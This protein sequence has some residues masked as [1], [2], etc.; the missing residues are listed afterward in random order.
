MVDWTYYGLAITVIIAYLWVLLEKIFK[1]KPMTIK[2]ENK[3]G[4]WFCNGRLYKD[5]TFE[6]KQFF[7][8]F[9]RETRLDNLVKNQLDKPLYNV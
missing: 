4:K 3:D 1:D 8:T 5:L 7:D 9:L 2:I 6:E